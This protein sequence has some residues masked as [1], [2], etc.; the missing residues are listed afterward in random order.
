MACFVLAAR[1]TGS[2]H[3]RLQLSLITSSH[4]PAA[5]SM[6]PLLP[7]AL[8]LLSCCSLQVP[9]INWLSAVPA[10]GG[11]VH[12]VVSV[13]PPMLGR[14]HLLVPKLLL[15]TLPVVCFLWLSARR[16]QSEDVCST[17]QCPTAQLCWH[18]IALQGLAAPV[19]SIALGR[20]GLQ[21]FF[22]DASSR[23][24]LGSS[25]SSSGGGSSASGSGFSNSSTSLMSGSAGGSTATHQASAGGST[26]SS[27]SSSGRHE[28]LLYRLSK[29][30]PGEVRC[31][32]PG[33]SSSPSQCGHLACS[34]FAAL[35]CTAFYSARQAV[36]YH[37]DA[38]PPT[39]RFLQSFVSSPT[40]IA[41]QGLL[42]ISALSAFETR[43]LY[44][45]SSG[46]H[47]VRAT[48]IPQ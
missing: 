10:V 30:Q 13:R 48:G 16:W 3:R 22:M 4:P 5:C 32:Q 29:D 43:T 36:Q 42:F 44:A 28:P 1:C 9:L 47:L 21:F 26:S 17:S 40:S 18:C 8:P 7:N 27:S 11:A 39:S 20:A 25:T 33:I 37:A 6:M 41:P 34:V 46:D 24:M 15:P 35:S 23:P 2:L 19:S 38:P 14:C 31:S 45:N 12:T